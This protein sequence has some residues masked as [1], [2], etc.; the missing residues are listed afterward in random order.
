MSWLSATVL[1]A[2]SAVYG[3]AP[4]PESEKPQLPFQVQLLET[5]IRFEAN[6]DSRKEVHTIVKIINILGAQQFARISFNYNRNFQSVEIPLVRVSHANGGTSE[7]LPSAVTDSPSAAAQPFP[8]YHDVRVKAVRILGLQEGDTVDYRVIT[9]TTKSP[10]AP[11]FWLEHTFDRSGQVLE[12]H[13]QLDLPASKKIDLRLNPKAETSAEE[14][15]GEGETARLVYRWTRKYQT[16]KNRALAEENVPN[17]SDVALST[18]N[19]EFLAV[20]LAELLLPGSK[21]ISGMS[22]YQNYAKELNRQPEVAPAI[23]EKANSLTQGAKN[24]LARLMAIYDF[25]STNITTVDLP[26]EATGFRSRPAELVL[27]SEYAT[28][29]DKYVLLAALATAVQL[30]VDPVLTGFCDKTA[31]PTPAVFKHL[32][33]VGSTRER[34]YWMDP[35]VEVAPFGMISPPGANCGLFLNRGIMALSS[36]DHEWMEIPTALPFAATQRVTVDANLTDSGQL[37][38]RVKYALRGENELLLRVAFHQTPKEKWKDVAGLLSLSDGF[39]GQVTKVDASDPKETREPFTVEYQLT[40]LNFVDWAKQPVRIPALLP[41]IGLPDAPAA[42]ATTPI[43]LGT[44]LDVQTTMTL[45]VPQ[46]TAIQTPAATTVTRDYASFS[47]KYAGSQN[48]VVA[49]RHITF[50]KK[51]LSSDRAADY[52]AFLHAVQSDSAQRIVLMPKPQAE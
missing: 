18:L 1:A 26:L 2:G 52:S 7:V 21:P 22:G 16:A 38:A 6:G 40:Q 10:L 3:Q 44:P 29:E 9:T 4:A 45:H 15:S 33:V 5:A 47:S 35:A 24:D 8:A 14:K 17:G 32:V 19:W 37:N 51:E 12:E 30:H 41:Q 23:R 49:S 42:G 13:Y 48:T 25:V 43:E 31:L 27:N 11:D 28:G 46:G 39:R 34:Q 20:R 50:L 36:P